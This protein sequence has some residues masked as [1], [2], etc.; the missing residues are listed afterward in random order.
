MKI[1]IGYREVTDVEVAAV[2]KAL[3]DSV[4]WFFGEG[5]DS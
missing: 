2:A 4:A 3:G 5:D 1:G